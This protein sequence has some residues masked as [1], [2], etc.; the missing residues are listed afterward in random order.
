VNTSERPS[1]TD[2]EAVR[3]W[4]LYFKR[5]GELLHDQVLAD[6]ERCKSLDK[7]DQ[8][9]LRAFW[10]GVSRKLRRIDRK[11]V[12]VPPKTIQELDIVWKTIRREFGFPLTDDLIAPDVEKRLDFFKRKIA[13]EFEQSVAEAINQHKI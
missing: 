12:S 2:E 10:Q 9:Y 1:L 7:F 8:S 6:A 11:P 3:L 4:A 13:Q 5:W